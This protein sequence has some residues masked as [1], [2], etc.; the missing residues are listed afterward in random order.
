MTPAS[1]FQGREEDIR[2]KHG[3][4]AGRPGNAK[5]YAQAI[6]SLAINNYVN[7][8]T[9][10]IDGGWLLENGDVD[11]FNSEISSHARCSLMRFQKLYMNAKIVLLGL[12]LTGRAAGRS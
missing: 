10:V 5:E 11:M 2:K 7:G 3:L 1:L 4:P 8:S 9:L 6:L 12:C